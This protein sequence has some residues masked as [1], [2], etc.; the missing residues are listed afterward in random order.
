[1]NVSHFS[2]E[3]GVTWKINFFFELEKLGAVQILIELYDRDVRVN[4]VSEKFE[5][6][7]LIN[8]TSQQLKDGIEKHGLNVSSVNSRMGTVYPP[9]V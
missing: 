1:M 6:L 4:L 8:S 3:S 7:Q 5:T 9:S 2:G